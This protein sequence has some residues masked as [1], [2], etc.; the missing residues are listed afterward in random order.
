MLGAILLLTLQTSPAPPLAIEER[1]AAALALAPGDTV[2]LRRAPGD[3]GRLMRVGAIYRPRSDPATVL[4]NEYHVR[5]HLPDLAQLLGTPD[6]IDRAGIRL[7]EGVGADSA[8]NRLDRLAVG[9]QVHPSA[10]I[11]AQSSR[12]FLV[13]SRFHRAIG[14]ISVVASA[15]FLLCI[16]LLKIEERRLDAAVMRMIGIRRRMVFGALLLEASFISLIGAAIGI[17]LAALSSGVINA[18]Y[19]ARFDTDLR[20]ALLTPGIAGFGAALSLLL[21]LAAGA[22]AAARLVRTPPLVLWRRG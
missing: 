9:F 14:V 6:R 22:I 19:A 13:V 16:M 20:F 8:A 2:R 21:G 5:L 15:I 17:G 18:Y 12:T 11:A 10:E 3:S 7:R 4:R 1:L